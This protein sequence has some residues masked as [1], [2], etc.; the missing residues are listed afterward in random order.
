MASAAHS[1]FKGPLG[2]SQAPAVAIRYR[3]HSSKSHS[4][5]VLRRSATSEVLDAQVGTPSRGSTQRTKM[6]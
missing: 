6:M 3:H 4:G 1:F 5:F 2:V